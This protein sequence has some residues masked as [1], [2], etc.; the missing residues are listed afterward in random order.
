MRVKTMNDSSRFKVSTFVCK[1][2]TKIQKKRLV[3]LN[4]QMTCLILNICN[5]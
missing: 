3:L 2:V 5:E 1:C 4:S